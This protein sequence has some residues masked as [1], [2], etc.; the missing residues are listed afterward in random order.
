[1]AFAI[2]DSEDLLSIVL[3]LKEKCSAVEDKIRKSLGLSVAEYR[4]LMCFGSEERISCQ[5]LSS[6]MN[7]SVS[8]GSRVIENL[9][10]KGFIQRV[11]CASDRRSKNVWLTKKGIRMRQKIAIQIQDCE[12]RLVAS[13]PPSRLSRFRSELK[14]LV[15]KF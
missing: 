14:T 8:R 5:E 6:R 11:D 2:M 3:S 1:M 13:I 4:G 15:N 12:D 7:L 10:K 9:F